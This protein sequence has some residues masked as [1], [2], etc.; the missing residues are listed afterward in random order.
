MVHKGGRG[1]KK[2]QKTVH[3]VCVWPQSNVAC[4]CAQH[5]RGPSFGTISA[6]GSNGAIIHYKPTE[7][8]DT[9]IGRDSLYLLDSGM[10]V[11]E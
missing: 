11:P 9:K 1:V 5:A 7:V 2:V 3:M 6:Y 10:Y 4:E 8:T